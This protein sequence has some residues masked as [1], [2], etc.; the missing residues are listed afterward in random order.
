MNRVESRHVQHM[1]DNV[2]SR[3]AY[4]CRGSQEHRCAAF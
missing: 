3:T 4:V 1:L 2:W